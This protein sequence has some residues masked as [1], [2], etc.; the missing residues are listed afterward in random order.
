MKQIT[1]VRNAVAVIVYA[2]TCLYATRMRLRSLVIT[3]VSTRAGSAR[4]ET[5][6][7]LPKT[8]FVVIRCKWLE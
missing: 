4:G 2:I 1:I 6:K 7:R 5:R 3:I 8:I